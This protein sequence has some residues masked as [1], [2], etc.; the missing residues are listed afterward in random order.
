[1]DVISDRR[2]PC[3]NPEWTPSRMGTVPN[4]TH[5]TGHRPEWHPSDWAPIPTGHPSRLGTH[6]D[7]A[8]IPNGAPF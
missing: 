5:P 2:D 8:P 3:R 6:P 7:W 1:M 4:G